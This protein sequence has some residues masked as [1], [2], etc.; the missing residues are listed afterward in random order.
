MIAVI[1]LDGILPVIKAP[2]RDHFVDAF[3]DVRNIGRISTSSGRIQ[4]FLF[5]NESLRDAPANAI[6]LYPSLFITNRPEK[7]GRMVP[8]PQNH[9]LKLAQV[10]RAAG[11]QSIFIQHENAEA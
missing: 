3:K 5:G 4:F 7:Y 1:T 11:H 6:G 10:F 2:D 9:S 8:V